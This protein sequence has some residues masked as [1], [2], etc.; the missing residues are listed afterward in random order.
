M[1][2]NALRLFVLRIMSVSLMSLGFLQ[3]S[4]AG[5]VDTQAL[6]DQQAGETGQARINALLERQD[7]ADQLLALGVD[8]ADVQARVASMSHAEIV[9][10]SERLETQVAGGDAI[11]VIGT[12]F[13]V[14]LILELVGVTDVF[15]SI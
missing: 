13:L 7:V 10:L 3:V 2:N 6:I 15:K 8:P 1:R 14:L 12:V 5:F 11:G 9:T 4:H